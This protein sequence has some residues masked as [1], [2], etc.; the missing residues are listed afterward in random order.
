MAGDGRARSRRA[1][2]RALTDGVTDTRSATERFGSERL[3]DVLAGATG[4]DPDE[5]ANRVDT[6]LLEFEDGPQRDD[7]ALLVLRA[8]A[9]P[10]AD[11]SLVAIGAGAA[12]APKRAVEK[13]RKREAAR[14]RPVVAGRS[15]CGV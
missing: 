7:V 1:T 6:A 5:V 8:T 10:G 4:L 13:G 9:G 14:K 3:A 12:A 11:A 15:R 2:A